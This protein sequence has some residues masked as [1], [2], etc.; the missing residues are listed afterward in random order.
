M[1]VELFNVLAYTSDKQ[2]VP[3]LGSTFQT[4]ASVTMVGAEAGEY[5]V[6]YAFEL[7]YNGTKNQPVY[8][9]MGGTFGS[10]TEFSSQADQDADHKNRFYMF[11]KTHAGGDIT[12]SLDMRKDAAIGT[13]DVDFVDVII[14]R[15]G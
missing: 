7:D 14:H 5:A 4:V 11:P 15:V 6:G 13:L 10:V 2:S 12:V 8:F 3:N 9:R 1:A